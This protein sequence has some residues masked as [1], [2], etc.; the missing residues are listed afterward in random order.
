[1][2]ASSS[3]ST[4]SSSTKASTVKIDDHDPGRRVAR[5]QAREPARDLAVRR[6]RVGRAGDPDHAG[7][8][9]LDQHERRDDRDRVARARRPPSSTVSASTTPSTG[10]STYWPPSSVP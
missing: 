6:E 3:M 9:G 10:A 2:P 8:G 4:G 7:V 1:M 5:V